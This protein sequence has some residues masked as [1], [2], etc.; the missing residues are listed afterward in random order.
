MIAENNA[1]DFLEYV[2][3]NKQMP[4]GNIAEQLDLIYPGFVTDTIKREGNEYHLTET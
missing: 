1:C 2:D 4:P 3:K